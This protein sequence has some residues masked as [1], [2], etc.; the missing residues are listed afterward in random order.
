MVSIAALVHECC[1]AYSLHACLLCSLFSPFSASLPA[2]V[3][4]GGIEFVPLVELERLREELKRLQEQLA[5]HTEECRREQARHQA[6]CTDQCRKRMDHH[7]AE[8]VRTVEERVAAC[9]RQCEARVDDMVAS[10]TSKLAEC[11]QAIEEMVSAGTECLN[12][13]AQRVEEMTSACD[14]LV[15]DK[16]RE[17]ARTTRA[18]LEELRG[19]FS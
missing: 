15:A 18:S 5:Q 9:I 2:Q 10:S 7:F 14:A 17:L 1:S 6:E 8:S 13:C 12:K 19:R 11:M 16:V 4:A 3:S